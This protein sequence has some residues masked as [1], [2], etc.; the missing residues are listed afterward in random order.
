MGSY[1]GNRIFTQFAAD[2][3]EPHLGQRVFLPEA[4]VVPQLEQVQQPAT[5]VVVPQA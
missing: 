4:Q 3:M 1:V 2:I 5:G